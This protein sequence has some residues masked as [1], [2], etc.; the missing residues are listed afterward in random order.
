MVYTYQDIQEFHKQIKELLDKRL[1]K[2][3][4]SPHISSA[5]MV[6]NHAEEKRGKVR[7]IINYKQLNNNT[8]FNT[9]VF[10]TKQSSLTE[11]KEPPSSQKW[12]VKAVIGK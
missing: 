4:K 7:M 6:R 5:F 11:F 10:L 8:L 9:T 2:N 3:S 1:I 12:I